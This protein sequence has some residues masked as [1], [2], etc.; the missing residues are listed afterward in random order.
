MENPSN[1]RNSPDEN[2][3]NWFFQNPELKPYIQVFVQNSSNSGYRDFL[4]QCKGIHNRTIDDLTIFIANLNQMITKIKNELCALFESIVPI[5]NYEYDDNSVN[6]TLRK[7]VFLQRQIHKKET[8]LRTHR[9]EVLSEHLQNAGKILAFFSSNIIPQ[10]CLCKLDPLFFNIHFGSYVTQDLKELSYLKPCLKRFEHKLSR[11]PKPLWSTS[12]KHFLFSL[13]KEAEPHIDPELSYCLP[14]ESEVSLSRCLF[15]PQSK[16]A[17]QIDKLLQTIETV[18]SEQFIQNLLEMCYS[19]IEARESMTISQQSIALLILF[20]AVFNRCYEKYGCISLEMSSRSSSLNN[21]TESESKSERINLALFHSDNHLHLKNKLS[22]DTQMF[23]N[24]NKADVD[25]IAKIK[26]LP[27]HIFPLPWKL[28]PMKENE[29]GDLTIRELF[30]SVP[31]YRNAGLFLYQAIFDSNPIDALYDIHKTLILIHKGALI[32]QIKGASASLEDV[33]Q[34][35]CFDDL[36]SLFFGTMTA[37]DIPD[38]FSL[39]KFIDLY[40]PKACLSPSFEYAQANIEA[41]VIHCRNIDIDKIESETK[42]E[43]SSPT[44]TE[45]AK[46]NRPFNDEN[47]LN[48]DTTINNSQTEHPQK[49]EEQMNTA[50]TND[51]T[52]SN[53]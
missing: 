20:R 29:C 16:F 15:N 12:F 7:I 11:V 10:G 17:F 36:F 43:L 50:E 47:E 30:D 38:I 5:T 6:F 27:A 26:A 41:L 9:F 45:K 19:L 18:P 40:A 8:L 33:N 23:F 37:S 48:I 52:T 35:L 39:A 3:K 24:T 51:H 49:D 32:N 1:Q 53:C 2:F 13:V 22:V 42:I 46:F 28:L 21:L 31:Y 44:F 25:K 34:I 14:L 4:K